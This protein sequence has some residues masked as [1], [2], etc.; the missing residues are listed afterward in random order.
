V[1]TRL[2]FHQ[3]FTRGVVARRILPTICVHMW[4]AWR[5]SFHASNGSGGHDP[6]SFLTFIVGI[7]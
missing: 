1:T 4:I 5:V 7:V 6:T 3:W 2:E